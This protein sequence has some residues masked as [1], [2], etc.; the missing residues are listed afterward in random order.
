MEGFTMLFA[1][2]ALAV[3]ALFTRRLNRSP[4]TLPMICVVLGGALYLADGVPGKLMSEEVII[5]A[6]VALA[7]VLFTDAAHLKIARLNE[8]KSWPARLLFL[9]MPLSLGIGILIFIPLFPGLPFWQVSLIA[10]L[11]VPTDAALGQSLAMNKKIPAHIRDTLTAES[12]LNDGLAL[13]FIIF[14]ACAAVG[15]NHELAP[16]NWYAFAGK[17]IGFGLGMGVVLG[18]IGGIASQWSVQKGYAVGENT[19]VF[20]LALVGATYFAADAVGGNSFVAVFAS[21][22]CFGRFATHCADRAKEFLETDGVL[23]MMVTFFF[24]GALM[25]PEG[26]AGA[27]W[28]II[29]AVAL[30]LFLIRPLAVYISMAGTETSPRARLFLGWFGPRGLAT[31]LFTL[32]VLGE[33]GEK[34]EG[35]TIL[36]VAMVAFAASTLLHGIT[37]HYA[38]GL[39]GDGGDV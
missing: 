16:E 13:P 17:Q 3:V 31:A 22:L 37:A 30:S 14:L 32:L 20:A 15:F 7:I 27:D 18:S 23:L 24:I 26:L 4:V 36:S 28:K 1:I 33:F 2:A 9:G 21:G 29:L 8:R 5:L 39:W 10:A 11:L 25:L 35:D 12:G 19:A 6:E 34:L 38:A